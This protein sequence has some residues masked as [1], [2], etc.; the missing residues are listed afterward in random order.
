MY[1]PQRGNSL[2]AMLGAKPFE[3]A[4]PRSAGALG[5]SR[6]EYSR[7]EVA[8]DGRRDSAGSAPGRADRKAR[9]ALYCLL[10]RRHEFGRPRQAG[11][12]GL[13]MTGTPEIEPG[14]AMTIDEAVGEVRQTAHHTC[15]HSF[16][17]V[18]SPDCSVASAATTQVLPALPTSTRAICTPAAASALS[19]RVT[20]WCRNVDGAR[21]M[22]R[23][24]PMPESPERPERAQSS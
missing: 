18:A 21:P 23:T 20:S 3:D 6:G 14:F 10:V 22:D 2:I 19:A 4:P 7:A 5:E 17:S 8:G 15:S 11:E 24:P 16:A 13:L 12:A 9:G 1:L